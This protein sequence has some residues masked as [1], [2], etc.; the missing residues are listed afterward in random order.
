MSFFNFGKKRQDKQPE[1]TKKGRSS[2]WNDPEYIKK[3]NTALENNPGK[4]AVKI[5]S[6]TDREVAE[7]R[8]QQS[9]ASLTP[10]TSTEEN[11]DSSPFKVKI[12][13][14]QVEREPFGII[15][16]FSFPPLCNS[17]GKYLNYRQYLVTG[18]GNKGRRRSLRLCCKTEQQAFD[19]AEQDGLT[20]PFDL[21]I[22]EPDPPTDRQLA[23]A[24]DLGIIIPSGDMK[25]ITKEDISHMIDR[26]TGEDSVESPD[27]D[28]LSMAEKL[29]WQGSAYIG[30]DKLWYAIV[31]CADDKTLAALYVYA[32]HQQQKHKKIGDMFAD[33]D[34]NMFFQFA[35]QAIA[36]ASVLKSIQGR[37]PGDFIAP[38]KGTTAYKAAIDFLQNTT[39]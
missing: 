16:R 7:K 22:I 33:P 11:Q 17:R 18:M 19:K 25:F 37:E 13:T 26:A 30:R 14:R 10:T 35:E 4:S 12:T 31:K 2:K 6:D 39:K 8:L 27:S 28:L 1:P 3:L 38:H 9:R 34:L 15:N 36:N 21:Q 5:I 32:V 20:A 23:Y 24:G 29:N